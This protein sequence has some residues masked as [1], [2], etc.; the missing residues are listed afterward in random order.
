MAYLV[1]S[2]ILLRWVQLTAPEHPMAVAAVRA[3]RLRGESLFITPQN[4]VEF[5]N[6]ATRPAAVNGLGLTPAQADA[7][8]Q[9]LEMLFPLLPDTAAIH[10]EWRQLVV[11]AAVSGRQVHDARLVAVM[12]AHGLTYLLTFNAADFVRYPGIT[13]VRPQDVAAP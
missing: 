9:R 1:D 4:E 10:A 5:W 13:V 8:L 7:E 2:N 3:L 6:A 12:Q 11:G